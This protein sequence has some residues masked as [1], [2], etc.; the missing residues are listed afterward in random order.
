[1]KILAQPIEMIAWFQENNQPRPLKFRM[2]KNDDTIMVV[3]IKQINDIREENIAGV[4]A[5]VYKCTSS[6]N[7]ILTTYELKYIINQCK[8]LLYKI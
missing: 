1:M 5:Y 4:K 7:G 3:K 6:V 8:W 2:K